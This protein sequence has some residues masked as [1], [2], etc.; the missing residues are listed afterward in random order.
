MYWTSEIPNICTPVCIAY[1]HCYT[2]TSYLK[3]GSF[4][5]NKK[6]KFLNEFSSKFLKTLNLTLKLDCLHK[7]L[8]G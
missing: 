1:R 2:K 6:T 7:E 8:N 3:F 5:K 4:E